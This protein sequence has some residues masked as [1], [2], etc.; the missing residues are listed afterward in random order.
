M[1]QIMDTIKEFFSGIVEPLQMIKIG[2]M[3]YVEIFIIAILI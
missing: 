1:A 2:V 3:D